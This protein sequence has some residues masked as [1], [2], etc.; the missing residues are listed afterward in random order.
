MESA[1]LVLGGGF[2]C[3]GMGGLIW[4]VPAM[5]MAWAL[6][7]RRDEE[8]LQGGLVELLPL[9]LEAFGGDGGDR[10]ELLGE[11]GDAELFDEIAELGE[12]LSRRSFVSFELS[13][14]LEISVP[15]WGDELEVF[16][17]LATRI[18]FA[19]R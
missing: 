14:E 2:F 18:G 6:F 9:L 1:A 10:A 16:G 3:S 19:A 15:E 8:L 5:G 7:N 17:I 13:F 4:G 12:L 11:S